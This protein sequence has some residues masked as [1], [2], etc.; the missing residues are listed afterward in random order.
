M[1]TAKVEVT[2]KHDGGRIKI[3]VWATS[4]ENAIEAVCKA[5]NAPKSAV[6]KAQVEKPTISDIKHET[7][8]TSPY[9]FDRKTLSFFGQRMADFSIARISAHE[10]RISAP[11]RGTFKTQTVRIYNA[12]TKELKQ[13]QNNE[14]Q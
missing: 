14:N 11:I 8:S 10:F 5:E 1:K 9:F 4:I 3:K 6:I 2:I 7:L 13:E 12:F